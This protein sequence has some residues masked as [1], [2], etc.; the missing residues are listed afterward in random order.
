MKGDLCCCEVFGHSRLHALR[1][2]NASIYV[3]TTPDPLLRGGEEFK[4]EHLSLASSPG[5]GR[6]QFHKDKV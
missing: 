6:L 3:I 2:M 1:D 4:I 5:K